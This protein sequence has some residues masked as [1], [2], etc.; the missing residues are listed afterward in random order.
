MTASYIQ[1]CALA[2]GWPAHF[3]DIGDLGWDGRRF[4]DRD[5]APVTDVFKLYP[6]EWML[7]EP[8]AAHL[9]TAEAPRWIE[10]LWKRVLS[11]KAILPVLWELFPGHP[12]LLEAS[13]DQLP[14]NHVRKPLHGREGDGVVVVRDGAEVADGGRRR[15]TERCVYQAYHPLAHGAGGH[16]VIGSW[17]VGHAAAGIGIR[18][19][20]GLVTTNRSRFVPHRFI[21]R[22]TP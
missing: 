10:P 18:E 12:N 1:D 2:A 14:G 15:P 5:D 16:A 3:L 21:P 22:S 9:V 8:F 20:R 4:V 19:D 7:A 17:V 13:F 6:W 11:T